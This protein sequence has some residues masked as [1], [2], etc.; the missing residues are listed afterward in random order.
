MAENGRELM[1]YAFADATPAGYTMIARGGFP[2][3]TNRAGIRRDTL[4]TVFYSSDGTKRDTIAEYGGTQNFEVPQVI[5]GQ[6]L[7]ASASSG[8]ARDGEIYMTDGGAMEVRVY[9]VTGALERVLR[10]M[11][12]P[13]PVTDEQVRDAKDRRLALMADA[14]ARF[15]EAVEQLPHAEHMPRI[16]GM[17]LDDANNLWVDEYRE[18]SDTTSHTSYVFAPDGRWLGTVAMPRHFELKAVSRGQAY[19]VWK[20]PETEVQFV[21]VYDITR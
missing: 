3:M 17:L 7:F 9:E 15:R 10:I 18:R 14:D 13:R 5:V 2:A 1:V 20:D 16:A 11:E 19:G 8:T 12:E 4:P 6:I 21:R